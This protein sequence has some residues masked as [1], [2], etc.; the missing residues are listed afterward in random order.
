MESVDLNAKQSPFRPGS[1][2]PPEIFVGREEE[3][4]MITRYIDQVSSG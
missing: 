3:V 2:A 4:D 1:P